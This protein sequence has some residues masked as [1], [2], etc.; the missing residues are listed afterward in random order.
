MTKQAKSTFIDIFSS[1]LRAEMKVKGFTQN[2]LAEIVKIRQTSIS[3]YLNGKAVPSADV[4]YRIALALEVPMDAL[5][6]EVSDDVSENGE[7]VEQRLSREN[8]TLKERIKALTTGIR[9]VLDQFDGK[10]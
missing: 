7:P 8:A 1:R 4:F 3:D 2:A 9:A 10:E 6:R 5:V